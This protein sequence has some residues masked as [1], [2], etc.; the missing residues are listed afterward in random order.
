[1]KFTAVNNVQVTN[2]QNL[3]AAKSKRFTVL[4]CMPL[5]ETIDSYVQ[6]FTM[7]KGEYR[8]QTMARCTSCKQRVGNSVDTHD[9]GVMI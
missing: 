8:A 5:R 6:V 1:V 9:T 7:R 4:E 2:K 3:R